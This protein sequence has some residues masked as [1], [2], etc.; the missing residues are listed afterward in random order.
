MAYAKFKELTK[1]FD[2]KHEMDVRD[3]QFY[4]ME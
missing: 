1:Y 2:F 4:S 3:L